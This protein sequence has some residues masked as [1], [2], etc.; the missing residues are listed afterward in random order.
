M[1]RRLILGMVSTFAILFLWTGVAAAATNYDKLLPVAKKYIGV[2]YSYGGTSVKGF[3]CS[4]YIYTVFKELGMNLPRTTSGL[5]TAGSSVDRSDLRIGDIVLFNTFGSGPSHAG[6]Y[7]GDNEF[8]HSSSSKGVSVSNLNDPY[9]WKDKYIGARRVLSYDLGVGEFK[10]IDNSH[11][12]FSAVNKLAKEDILL[13]YEDSYFQPQ[14]YISRA[15]VAAML[16]ESFELKVNDRSSNFSDVS[17][18]HWGVGAINAVLEEGIFKGNDSNQFRPEDALKRGQMAAIISRA[19]DLK[20]PSTPTEFTDVP[21]DHWAYTDIQKLAASGITVGY[22]D[23]SFKPDGYVTRSQFA[24][25]LYR[26]MY[27]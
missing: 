12:V 10:D 22:P 8:I 26:A 2:P 5:A 27:E 25:F 3:D 20:A 23:G 21:S 13:G 24:A 16:A 19:F 9:Y 14:D 15:E 1:Y 4:G 18:Y 17:T 11:W 6:I 7:I